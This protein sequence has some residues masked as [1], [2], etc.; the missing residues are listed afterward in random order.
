MSLDGLCCLKNDSHTRYETVTVVQDL[1]LQITMSLMP[2]SHL[3]S[4]R[5]SSLDSQYV[6]SYVSLQRELE[7]A[8]R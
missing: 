4:L 8:K 7:V 6:R 2:S 5:N 3:I 1:I